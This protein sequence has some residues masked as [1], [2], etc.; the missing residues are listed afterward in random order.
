MES[1][2]NRGFNRREFK[3]L[4]VWCEQPLVDSNQILKGNENTNIGSGRYNK[5]IE[6]HQRW[7]E[8]EK[9]DFWEY[10]QELQSILDMSKVLL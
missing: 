7:N 6:N 2:Q 9:L 4:S 3:E 10:S 8:K 5:K 1:T